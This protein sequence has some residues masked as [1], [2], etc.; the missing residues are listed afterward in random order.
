MNPK[1]NRKK[2]KK[3]DDAKVEHELKLRIPK[4]A[5]PGTILHFHALGQ[6]AHEPQMLEAPIDTDPAL[7]KLWPRSKR[8]PRLL[9]G[10]FLLCVTEPK[11]PT[12]KKPEP[13]PDKK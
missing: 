9:D 12:E 5:V 4:D 6:T 8:L 10:A 13:D 2:D 3:D 7:Q 1:K 11:A